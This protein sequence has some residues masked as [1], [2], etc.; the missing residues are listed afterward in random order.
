MLSKCPGYGFDDITQINILKNEFQHQHKITQSYKWNR[1]QCLFWITFY[2]SNFWDIFLIKYVIWFFYKC[3][4]KLLDFVKKKKLLG[5]KII[6]TL[7]M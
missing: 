5:I 7:L 3:L 1:V 2:K 4:T 6:I